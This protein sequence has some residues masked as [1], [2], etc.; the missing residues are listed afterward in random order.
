MLSV[1]ASNESTETEIDF[2]LVRILKSHRLL[3]LNANCLCVVIFSS[4][5]TMKVKM[6]PC[7]E[8]QYHF[9][10]WLPCQMDTVSDSVQ[11]PFYCNIY[12]YI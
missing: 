3:I 1:I 7:Q 5:M 4:L 8:G 10:M 12:I 6:D 9:T 2:F 11:L